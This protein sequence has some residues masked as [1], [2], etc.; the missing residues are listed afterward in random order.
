MKELTFGETADFPPMKPVIFIFLTVLLSACQP[1]ISHDQ[2]KQEI[3]DHGEAIRDAFRVADVATISSL[4][5]PEVVKALGYNNVQEGREAVIDGIKQT[6]ESVSLEF[7]NNDVENFYIQQD[8]V[9]EQTRF[10]IKGTPKD[11]GEPFF[12]SGRTMVT[13]VRHEESPTGWATIREIIQPET[14]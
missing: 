9:I 8:L 6:L 11:G 13:Y 10:S 5:H 2:I 14:N 4:H 3:L 7:V 12:F 1:S